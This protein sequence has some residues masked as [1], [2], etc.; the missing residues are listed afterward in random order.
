MEARGEINGMRSLDRVYGPLIR[1][2]R[3]V[4]G[5][6][7]DLVQAEEYCWRVGGGGGERESCSSGLRLQTFAPPLMVRERLVISAAKQDNFLAAESWLNRLRL[8]STHSC[9]D[10]FQRANP[11][12]THARTPLRPGELTRAALSGRKHKQVV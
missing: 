4:K 6:H 7:V 10:L 1:Q 11:P 3:I 8:G 5:V 9:G 12:H 2:A